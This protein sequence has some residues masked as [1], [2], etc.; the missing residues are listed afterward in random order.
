VSQSAP[1][2]LTSLV[3]PPD[4]VRE[5]LRLQQQQIFVPPVK[6]LPPGQHLDPIRLDLGTLRQLVPGA[7]GR[8]LGQ[9]DASRV[10][11]VIWSEGGDELSVDP[12]KIDVKTT[13]GAILFAIPVRCDQSG[14]GVAEVVLAVGS[15]DRA[16]GMFAVAARRPVGPTAVVERWSD[17]LIALAWGTLVELVSAVS[18]VAGR[19]DN[20]DALIPGSIAA[21]EGG[22]SV[23]PYA[24]HRL[25]P[26]LK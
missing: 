10:T 1:T 8:V 3:G 22:L 9:S 24:R 13:T 19:D 6:P 17:A 11:E 23:V 21:D 15:P 2:D 18:G 14:Q 12:V 26:L 20:G 5:L 25:G 4:V 7:A 16:A